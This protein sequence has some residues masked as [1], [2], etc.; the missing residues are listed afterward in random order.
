MSVVLKHA[1]VGDRRAVGSSDVRRSDKIQGWQ[2]ER[3]AV[4]YVRQSTPHQVAEHQ[5][6]TRLQYGLTQRAYDLGWPESRIVV[7]DEDLGKSGTSVVGRSGFQRLVTEVSLDRVGVILGVEMS[8]LARSCKDW[9]QLLEIC[10]LFGTLLADLDGVYDPSQ[11]ND[12]LLLG[13]KGVMSET[14]LHI[15]QQ[16][17]RQGVLH[18]ASRGELGV[19]PPLGYLRRPSGEVVLDPDE[20]VQGVVRLVFRKFAELGTVHAVL[21]Y[22]VAHQVQLGMRAHRG[23]EQ[24]EVVWHRPNRVTLQNILKHPTYAGAYVY[25][26]RRLDARRKRAECPT[27]GRVV[28]GQTEWA[29]LLR[30]R[31]PAYI[32]WEQ[33]E[34]NQARL[35]ANQARATSLG[36][37]R[38][39]PALLSGVLSCGFCGRRLAVQYKDDTHFRYGCARQAIDYGGTP[40]QE[41][42][43]TSLDAFVSAQ[44]L[45][46]LA[47]AALELSL[48]AATHLAQERAD[49]DRLW[50]QRLER[51]RYEADRV[52]RQYRLAEPENRLVTRQLERAWEER[53]ADLEHLERAYQQAQATQPRTISADEVELIRQLATNIPALWQA[54][55]TTAAD[56]KEIIRQVVQRVV[57]RVQGESEQVQVTIE[58]VGGTQTSGTLVRPVA[59][60]SQLSYYPTLCQLVQDWAAAGETCA[61]MAQR[62]NQAGYRPPKRCERFTG[63]IV[64]EL[65][66]QLHGQARQTRPAPPDGPGPTEWY[67]AD[68]ARTIG[69]PPVTLYHWLQRGWVIGRQEHQA[70]WRWIIQAD[71]SEVA[72]L[73][74]VHLR[75]NGYYTRGRWAAAPGAMTSDPQGTAQGAE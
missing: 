2:Y 62:L 29:V 56:R 63:P 59:R 5:E 70:P 74:D 73:R 42:E 37:A 52:G 25:G 44:V 23:P 35:A 43:G 19:V 64:Q 8:R 4:V 50:Q 6:S 16:R 28:V 1:L 36:V 32:S 18:K 72:H 7:I 47:P 55:T 39:G 65:L 66:R 58:W 33:Y 60:F 75:P 15:M 41:L 24:G 38:D 53:L 3:L 22:L 21:R 54:A 9:Y 10:A 49:L 48:A 46:A 31:L 34:Q 57:V 12:R 45:G 30:D 68:L 20:Q 14:E 13:L 40:C 69:M 67:L 71:A 51:A 11:Y 17:L 61:A 27:S 26:R